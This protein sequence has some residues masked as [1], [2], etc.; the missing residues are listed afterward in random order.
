MALCSFQSTSS[1]QRLQ[2]ARHWHQ[3]ATWTEGNYRWEEG[4]QPFTPHR[5][6][7]S[8]HVTP[9]YLQHNLHYGPLEG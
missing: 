6:Q 1:L 7:S 8:R 3:G 2:H 5:S 9:G 4:S